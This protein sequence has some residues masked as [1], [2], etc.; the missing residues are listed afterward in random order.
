MNSMN[1]KVKKSIIGVMCIIGVAFW[2]YMAKEN[3][4]VHFN[5]YLQLANVEALASTEGSAGGS[6]TYCMGSGSID[7]SGHKVERKIVAFSPPLYK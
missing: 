4:D 5:T 2:A 7:C 3:S 1:T 6:A